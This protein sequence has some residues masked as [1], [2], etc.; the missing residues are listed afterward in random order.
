MKM[1]RSH[2]AVICLLLLFVAT[3]AAQSRDL[4]QANAPAVAPRAK[5]GTRTAPQQPTNYKLVR[6]APVKTENGA[7][8]GCFNVTKLVGID[9]ASQHQPVKITQCRKVRGA[10]AATASVALQL[11]MQQVQIQLAHYAHHMHQTSSAIDVGCFPYML[12]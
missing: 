3:A 12:L 1:G 9:W 6:G 5:I 2:K 8:V 10:A 7:F 11:L 4:Q